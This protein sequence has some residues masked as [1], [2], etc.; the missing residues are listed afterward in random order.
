MNQII[1]QASNND[2]RM[3]HAYKHK[4][5]KAGNI[6]Q[7]VHVTPQAKLWEWLEAGCED[8][9]RKLRRWYSEQTGSFYDERKLLKEEAPYITTLKTW[10][11]A[12]YPSYNKNKKQKKN[13]IIKNT[14]T[15]RRDKGTLT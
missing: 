1:I 9:H 12:Y 3:P 7:T 10:D 14:E 5:A 11:I 4:E 8:C 2:Y 6:I 15:M 13:E